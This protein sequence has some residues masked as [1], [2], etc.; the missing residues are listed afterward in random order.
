MVIRPVDPADTEAL[1]QLGLAAWRKG[2]KPHVLPERARV[3][4]EQN[5]FL[6][7]L[8]VCWE[9]IGMAKRIVP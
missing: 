2:I 6:L 9:K 3:V 8:R 4:E 7:F 1:A 5:P